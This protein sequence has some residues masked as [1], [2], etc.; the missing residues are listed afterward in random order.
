MNWSDANRYFFDLP[1]VLS[2]VTFLWSE[3]RHTLKPYNS[4]LNI[5]ISITAGLLKL[6]F[7]VVLAG[8]IAKLFSNHANVHLA[9][10]VAVGAS[11][12]RFHR[13]MA[14]VILLLSAGYFAAIYSQH[15]SRLSHLEIAVAIGVL[16]PMAFK[17]FLDLLNISLVR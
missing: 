9:I 3:F 13:N 14:A 1:I 11:T 4:P 6:A 2:L 12:L 16:I 5:R 8:S 10:V 7:P 17:K 15:S